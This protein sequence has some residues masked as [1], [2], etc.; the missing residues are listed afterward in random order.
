MDLF[1]SAYQEIND[2]GKLKGLVTFSDGRTCKV[3]DD[4]LHKQVVELR[5]ERVTPVR[6]HAY[7]SEKWGWTLKQIDRVTS[8]AQAYDDARAKDEQRGRVAPGSWLGKR[9]AK[10][11]A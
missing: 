2:G 1:I 7:K 8:Y 11:V 4:D 9:I 6:Y 3:W 5:A 10:G